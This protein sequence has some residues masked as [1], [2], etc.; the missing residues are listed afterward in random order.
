[1]KA[2][3]FPQHGGREVLQFV[4]DFPKPSPGR[5]EILIR[6]KT[7][8]I[9]N[10]DLVNRRGYPGITI[11]LPHILGGDIAGEVAELG[12]GVDGPEVG[13]RV[14]V[15][16]LIGCGT[17]PQ[18]RDGKPNICL[19]W[20]FIGMHVNG[21]YAEYVSVPVENVLPISISYEEAVTL[22]VAG[23]T[24]YHGL[25]T[26]GGLKPNQAFLIWGGA[27]GLGSMA[28]QIAKRLGATVIATAGSGEKLEFMRKLGADYVFNR[29]KDD[30]A[31]EVKKI[32][33]HGV[34]L[35]LD[36]VG[37]QT[38]QTSFDMLKK[39]G[40]MLLCGII[41]GR[42]TNFSIHQTY[43]RHLSI[44][45]I[46]LGTQSEMRELLELVEKRNIKPVIGKTL[47]LKD[48]SEGHRLMEAGESIGKIALSVG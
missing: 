25:V 2:V 6:V 30:L 44:R 47:P 40:T 22:P 7:A 13:T 5:G 11:P 16:P 38:F 45:G 33:P 27:G 32:A 34:D 9:N 26:E 17:C 3:I 1:M 12:E 29:H 10:V 19:Q 20:R 36:Y 31:A 42:E 46:Y 41:T 28:I 48:A 37:P 14:V 21:G 23:L 24:A 35:V 39:G 8:G 4:S 15:Y 18:C 43:L